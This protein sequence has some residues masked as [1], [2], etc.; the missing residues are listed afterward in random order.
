MFGLVETEASIFLRN[1][2]DEDC[3]KEYKNGIMQIQRIK[4]F[5]MIDIINLF[6]I[7]HT[8]EACVL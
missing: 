5:F 1:A 8:S 4:I 2:V 3:A 7:L 6:S